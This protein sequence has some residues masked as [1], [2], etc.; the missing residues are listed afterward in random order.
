MFAP[1][2]LKGGGESN[3][4]RRNHISYPFLRV[5][6]C[7]PYCQLYRPLPAKSLA[8]RWVKMLSYSWANAS[9]DPKL[10]NNECATSVWTNIC[11]HCVICAPS[12]RMHRCHL[13][14]AVGPKGGNSQ[15]TWSWNRLYHTSSVVCDL[16]R[17]WFQNCYIRCELWE[18]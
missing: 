10:R 11:L 16:Q 5:F 2:L 13:W 17:F 14:V 8:K 18:H 12:D 7:Q 4:K 9:S 15:L 6:K 3:E 1:G